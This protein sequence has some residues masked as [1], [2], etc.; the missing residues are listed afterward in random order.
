MI[1]TDFSILAN[2][3]FDVCVVGSGPVGA[4]LAIDLA[5]RGL[6]VLVLELGLVAPDRRIQSLSDAVISL[7][8]YHHPMSLAVSR[9]LGGTSALWGGRCVPLDEIDFEKR[10]FL[11]NSGWPISREDV[12]PYER[13]AAE[14]LGCDDGG[15]TTGTL[16]NF[17]G[18]EID[19]EKLERWV[20]ETRIVRQQP[21]LKN[22]NRIV[23]LLNATVTSFVIEAGARAING[24]RVARDE[25][26]AEFN[27]AHDY[28]LAL[29]GIET[30]RLLLNVQ[31]A[32]PQLFG[33]VSG[34]LGRY[35]MGHISGSFANIRFYNAREI[36]HFSNM[37]GKS[38][39]ARRRLTFSTKSQLN[40]ELPNIAFWPENSA[41]FDAEHRSGFL[42]LVFM[43]LKVPGLQFVP[44]A[45][46]TAQSHKEVS[47]WPHFRNL[48]SDFGG[49]L[50]GTA[51]VIKQRYMYGRRL[52]RLLGN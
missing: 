13:R 35:Y 17:A 16:R 22:S 20:N 8:Q 9:M 47:I 34:A 2:H 43:M 5:Y 41:L 42:S 6:S 24:L 14:L 19:S 7:P 1:T 28:V 50:A 32:H 44:G 10:E 11:P 52:P 36:A 40:N 18:S 51:E 25:Q 46:Q 48:I 27:G 15:F 49:V 45:I 38:S 26:T 31:A 23:V 33:G 21:G 3:K 4:C 37:K 30:A 12:E 29:G 39:F